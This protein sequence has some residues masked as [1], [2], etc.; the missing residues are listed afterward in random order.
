MHNRIR[1]LV[2]HGIGVKEERTFWTGKRNL[3]EMSSKKSGRLTSKGKMFYEV[4]RR[5][6]GEREKPCCFSI[7]YF[8]PYP[9]AVRFFS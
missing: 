5:L 9:T 4:R 8:G 7:N 3:P 6:K 1:N 2:R